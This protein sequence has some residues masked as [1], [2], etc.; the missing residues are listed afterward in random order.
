MLLFICPKNIFYILNDILSNRLVLSQNAIETYGIRPFGTS[1]HF[2]TSYNWLGQITGQY[3][4]ID[5]AYVQL[6]FN[7]YK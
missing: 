3:N 5:S 7:C 4:F 6:F 1:I 2:L